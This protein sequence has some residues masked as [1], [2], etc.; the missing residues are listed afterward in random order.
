M[1]SRFKKSCKWIRTWGTLPVSDWIEAAEAYKKKNYIAA[2]N[3]YRRGLECYPQHPAR[4]CALLDLAFCHFKTGELKVAEELLRLVIKD[5]PKSREA[6]LRLGKTL[7]WQGDDLEAVRVFKRALGFHP[8]DAE[9]F[10]ELVFAVTR[11]DGPSLL[12]PELQKTYKEIVARSGKNLKLEV[13]S[14][15]LEM[16]SGNYRQ[17]RVN[18][19]SLAGK[20]EAPFEAHYFFGCEL[21]KEG[22]VANARV[23]LRN[24]LALNPENPQVLGTL[25]ET[26]MISGNFQNSEYA[27]QL[28]LQAAQ[29]SSWLS[30]R[31][32]LTLSRSYL[33][34]GEKSSALLV[35]GKAKDVSNQRIGLN[36]NVRRIDNLISDLSTGTIS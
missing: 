5:V 32:L 29:A 8:Y 28:A 2:R 23:H 25:A 26:Y 11:N 31:E 34:I 9:I 15:V 14:A 16:L 36:V 4:Y 13:A 33:G 22:K 3:L 7:S 20:L 10:S 21:L 17:G 35:A 30:P 1:L 19:I 27:N 24:A 18:L 12:V 6:S